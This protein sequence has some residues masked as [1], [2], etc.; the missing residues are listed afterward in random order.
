M[1][2]EPYIGLLAAQNQEGLDIIDKVATSYTDAVAAAGGVPIIL[3]NTEISDYFDLLDGVLLIGG[4]SDIDPSLYGQENTASKDTNT[5]KD[6]LEIEYVHKCLE[7]K[8][9]F[10][11]ICRG[12][13]IM[14]VALGGTLIQHIQTAI[15][16]ADYPHQN[17]PA[18][19]I[20]VERSFYVEGGVYR[21]NSIHHQAVDKLGTG[22]HATAQALDG[23]VEMIEPIESSDHFFLGVQWHPECIFDMPLSKRLF[24]GFIASCKK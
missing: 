19:E 8:K 15:N 14:N 16:H 10:F 17:E 24:E 18:H 13:Q 9:P 7:T 21:V 3:P 23:I 22:L 2:N 12:M 20:T 6:R 1:R 4:V 5:T 11:G